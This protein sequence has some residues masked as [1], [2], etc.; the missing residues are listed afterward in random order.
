MP[1]RI[2]RGYDLPLE[3]VPQQVIEPARPTAAV[4][5]LGRDYLDLRPSMHV[6]EGDRVRLGQPLFSDRRREG[7][8]VTSPGS[9]VVTTVLRGARRVLQSVI[10][11]LEGEDEE[12]FDRWDPDEL[13]GLDRDLVIGNLTRSGLWCALRTRPWSKVPDPATTPHALFITATDTNPLAPDPAVVIGESR[14]DFVNGVSVLSRLTTGQTFVCTAA[15]SEIPVP[16]NMP[17]IQVAEFTGPHPAGLVGT[18]IH[19]LYPVSAERSVWHL[20]Y[21]DVI[22]VGRLFTT[23]RLDPSRVVSLGGPAVKRPRLLRTRLGAHIEPLV[24]GEIEEGIECRVLSGSVW[25]GYRATGWAGYLG[26]YH[27]Q[28]TVIAEGR[29][30]EFIGWLRPGGEKVSVTR[31]FLSS[32]SSAARR[33]A[34]NTSQNGSPRAMVPI[35]SYERVMPLEILPTQLLRALVVGDT[36]EAQRLGALELDEE[37][38]A[39]CT[40]VCPGKYDY[41]P[42]L[43]TRLEQIEKEG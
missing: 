22:A 26:R 30:R 1:T 7:V 37:D 5:V 35:G 25:S 9:G 18:H 28:V 2:R 31:A 21:Q 43:R 27:Q 42:V 14:E 17:G 29:Q 11:R 38:L 8:T 39:L 36:D 32:F 34:L 24:Q 3:G 20:G 16:G 12:V 40:F 13:A 41:G 15:G 23:G 4:A 33:F 19:F 10:I 6:Q